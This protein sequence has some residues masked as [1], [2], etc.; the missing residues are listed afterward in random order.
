MVFQQGNATTRA[1]N[2]S[3]LFFSI[4][5][6]FADSNIF[7]HGLA[8]LVDIQTNASKYHNTSFSE[9]HQPFSSLH[10][11]QLAHPLKSPILDVFSFFESLGESLPPPVMRKMLETLTLQTVF[12]DKT[13]ICSNTRCRMQARA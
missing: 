9:I 13:I 11:H 12:S 1:I 4:Q 2:F 8:F 7:F 6:S 10:S 5:R 3:D